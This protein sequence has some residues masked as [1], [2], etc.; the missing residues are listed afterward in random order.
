MSLKT[1]STSGSRPR[2]L[3]T[4]PHPYEQRQE[5]RNFNVYQCTQTKKFIHTT[6]E[7]LRIKGENRE[8]VKENGHPTTE[9]EIKWPI[10]L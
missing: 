1:S 9:K 2:I 7:E 4:K 3:K 10:N 6:Y 8:L 5:K